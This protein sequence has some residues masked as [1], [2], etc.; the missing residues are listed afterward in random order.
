MR[1]MTWR[2]VP[3]QR[4][5]LAGFQ[6]LLDAV[7]RER[8]YLAFLEA[9]VLA[10]TRRF[11]LANLRRNAPQYIALD[12]DAV[13]GWCDVVPRPRETL[14]HGGVLGMGVAPSHRGRGIGS[15]LLQQTIAAST[16]RGITRI[17]LVV[18][19]DNHAAI[20][21]YR[22]HRF[23]LEGRLRE[24]LVVDGESHDA[25]QMARLA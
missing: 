25:L 20:N 9:P 4:R 15:A 21:L 2:I 23:Y 10:E 22:R 16:G 7:A 18:R 19:A 8:R 1:R 17:E 6:A 24:Y 5:H 14:R 11:V 3:M 13:V 12:G